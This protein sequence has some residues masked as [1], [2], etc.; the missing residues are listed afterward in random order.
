MKNRHPEIFR[1]GRPAS[2]PAV[3]QAAKNKAVS[4]DGG[5]E[6]LNKNASLINDSVGFDEQEQSSSRVAK[7]PILSWSATA[8]TIFCLNAYPNGIT[9]SV[10]DNSVEEPIAAEETEPKFLA[11]QFHL[12]VRD[13]RDYQLPSG[14][15]FLYR[16]NYAQALEWQLSQMHK[17]GRLDNSVLY[18][19]TVTDPFMSFRKKFEVTMACVELLE[20]YRPG[21]VVLQTRSPMAIAVLPMLKILGERAVVSFYIETRL[22]AAVARYTPGL[23]KISERLVAADGLR[24]QGVRVTLCASPMLP[25]GDYYR[26]AWAFAELLV[27]N[28]DFISFGALADGGQ[29]YENQLKNI[30]LSQRLSSDNQFRLLRPNCYRQVY[31]AVK[32][33][34]PE[35]LQLPVE[36]AAQRAMQLNL[37]AA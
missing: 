14:K 10:H 4:I 2:I 23:P 28:G 7:E 20:N 13:T 17:Q 1:A 8:P 27:K 29:V 22:E 25:Y 16:E 31:Q 30:P 37:F 12:R 19:G 35:K 3:K 6:S 26:D 34:A 24:K 32:L 33:M 18:F 15:Y 11:Q 36:T 9:F 5:F 21:L